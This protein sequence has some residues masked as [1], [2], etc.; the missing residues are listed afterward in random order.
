MRMNSRIGRIPGLTV[1]VIAGLLVIEVAL[2]FGQMEHPVAVKSRK[3]NY[4]AMAEVPER[5][6]RKRNPLE[7]DPDA[8][9]AGRKLFQQRCSECH[10]T[11][12]WGR[13]EVQACASLRC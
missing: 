5:A 13:R 9:A 12:G 2:A 3:W 10:G 7:N 1:L 6:R 8:V 11:E 4:A